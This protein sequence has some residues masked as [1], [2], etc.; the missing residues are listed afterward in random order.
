MVD[1]RLKGKEGRAVFVRE[2]GVGGGEG[3]VD[4]LSVF[5][6]TV[7]SFCLCNQKN[8]GMNSDKIEGSVKNQT[9]I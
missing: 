3:G 9:Q 8:G 7:K 1:W 5:L 6:L 4:S 2:G